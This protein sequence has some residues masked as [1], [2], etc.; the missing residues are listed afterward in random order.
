[1]FVLIVRDLTLSY[2]LTGPG[3]DFDFLILIN[4][5][6]LPFHFYGQ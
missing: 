6:Q 5:T 2:F 1:M 3:I 4:L